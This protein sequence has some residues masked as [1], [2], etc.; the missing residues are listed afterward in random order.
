M[1]FGT[2]GN[3][4][5]TQ[6]KYYVKEDLNSMFR[7][8]LVLWSVW[9]LNRTS[10]DYFLESSCLHLHSYDYWRHVT[11]NVVSCSPFTTGPETIRNSP[12]I[13]NR[14][15]WPMLDHPFRH[16]HAFGH[17]RFL[18]SQSRFEGNYGHLRTIVTGFLSICAPL[19]AVWISFSFQR[20]STK[21]NGARLLPQA[22]IKSWAESIIVNVWA[23]LLWHQLILSLHFWS[24]Y[25]QLYT[26]PLH[27]N[28]IH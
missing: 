8:E 11:H 3:T 23:N 6:G 27:Q 28:L 15:L 20:K 1:I 13:F 4:A 5:T 16:S 14:Y 25:P 17:K 24:P 19:S 10:V 9:T 2:Q 7:A 22:H 18:K 21:I 12:V 26:G